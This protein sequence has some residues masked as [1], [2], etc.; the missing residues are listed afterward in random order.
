MDPRELRELAY[1]LQKSVVRKPAT[2]VSMPV[3]HRVLI[4]HK[5]SYG[6]FLG[7]SSAR[8]RRPNIEDPVL[9]RPDHRFE[10]LK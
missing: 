7:E 3:A 2:P 10:L 4:G 5:Q 9:A 8:N 1:A 6:H